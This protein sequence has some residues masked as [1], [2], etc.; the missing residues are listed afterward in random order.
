MGGTWCTFA[1]IIDGARRLVA[2]AIVLALVVLTDAALWKR[3]QND[4]SNL[5]VLA[6][7]SGWAQAFVSADTIDARGAVLANMRL[8]VIDVVR[9]ILP[10]EAFGANTSEKHNQNYA[11]FIEDSDFLDFSQC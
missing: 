3:Q 11:I 1:G 8:T 10:G 7:V 4:R 9:A 5:A 2:D 6:G